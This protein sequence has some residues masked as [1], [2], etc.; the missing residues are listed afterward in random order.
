M[1]IDQVSGFR[2]EVE[3]TDAIPHLQ[4]RM[5]SGQVVVDTDALSIEGMN[6]LALALTRA[7]R[8]AND[9]L[10]HHWRGRHARLEQDRQARL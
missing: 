7:A 2:V 9:E 4:I 5:A 8:I 10:E 1:L 3:V 6:N